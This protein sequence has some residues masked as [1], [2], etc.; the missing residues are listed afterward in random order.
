MYIICT[1]SLALQKNWMS[2]FAKIQWEIGYIFCTEFLDLQ[3][4]WMSWT[5][6]ILRKFNTLYVRNVW[7][8]R[9]IKYPKLRKFNEKL[10]TDVRI[11]WICRKI[12]HLEMHNS[13]RNCA[14]Y[15]Y[16]LSGFAEKLNIQNC[17]S[18][19]GNCVHFMYRLF[20]FAENWI[21]RIAWIQREIVYIRCTDC[22]D[23]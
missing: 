2:R 3:K 6:L 23:L 9:K 12:E 19:T 11:F 22:L 17:V 18:S 10:R 7:I 14:H 15:L 13:T 20:G 5:P 8:W 16:G 1:E 4:N 21:S